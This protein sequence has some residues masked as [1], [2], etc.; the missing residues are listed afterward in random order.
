[1]KSISLVLIILGFISCG[2]SDNKPQESDTTNSTKN[3]VAEQ[4][5][6]VIQEIEKTPE[7]EIVTDIAE[8]KTVEVKN[9]NLETTSNLKPP[10]EAETKPQTTIEET[11]PELEKEIVVNDKPNHQAWNELAKKYVSASGKVNYKGFKSELDKL[12]KYID[13]LGENPVKSSWSKNEE[14]AYWFNLYNASTVYLITSNYPTSSIT[15]LEKGKPWDKKFIK[16]GDKIYSLNDIENVIVRPK[17][18]EPL[19][20]VAFNCAAVSCPN[21]LNEA[22]VAEKLTAQL[23]KQVKKWVNDVSKNEL[24][25]DKIMV[26]QIFD[27]YKTDFDNVGGVIGFINKYSNTKVNEKAK[28]SYL[29]YNWNL[30]E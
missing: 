29:E 6:E 9:Q 5:E 18:K 17:F 10:T 7:E 20:H 8:E 16:S 3:I 1:M 12:K 23:T 27:W 19:V 15:K 11:L 4:P 26:S 13:Y 21:L 28:I 25:P 30:N 14:L 24:T 2:N 22:F